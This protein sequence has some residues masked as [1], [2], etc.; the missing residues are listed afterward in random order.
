MLCKIRNAFLLACWCGAL[1]VF[2]TRCVFMVPVGPGAQLIPVAIGLVRRDCNFGSQNDH[3]HSKSSIWLWAM[4]MAHN[5]WAMR[6]ATMPCEVPW[7][8]H[9]VVTHWKHHSHITSR[10]GNDAWFLQCKKCV[11]HFAVHNR[12]IRISPQWHQGRHLS[13]FGGYVVAN[14]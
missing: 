12:H 4:P 8:C 5:P 9:G 14:L 6:M 2:T 1:V 7:K 10:C 3:V 11:S 13:V